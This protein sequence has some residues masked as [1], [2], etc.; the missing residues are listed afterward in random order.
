MFSNISELELAKIFVYA[1]QEKIKELL[2][3]DVLDTYVA[4]EMLYKYIHGNKDT[5]WNNYSNKYE[6]LFDEVFFTRVI[7]M[8]KDLQ[9]Q[10]EQLSGCQTRFEPNIHYV[11]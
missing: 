8:F 1:K 2:G 9:K 6:A 3:I 10:D 4:A 7:N 5:M 11:S